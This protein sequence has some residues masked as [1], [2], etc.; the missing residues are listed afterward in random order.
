MAGSSNRRTLRTGVQIQEGWAVGNLGGTATNENLNAIHCTSSSNCWGVAD[1]G[2]VVYWNGSTWTQDAFVAAEN[3]N[4]ISCADAANC[5]I[6]GDAG[7]ASQRPYTIERVGG[8]AWNAQDNSALNINQPLNGVFCFAGGT[9]WAVGDPD[10]A[11]NERPLILYWNGANWTRNNSNLNIN[12]A[13][14]GVTCTATN[15]CWAVG[16]AGV[17]AT[18]RPLI[19]YWD[20]LTATWQRRNSGLNVNQ[21]LNAVHCFDDSSCMAVGNNGV[22]Y[23]WNGANWTARNTGTGENLNGVWCTAANSCFAVGDNG[24][25][26]QWSGGANWAAVTSGTTENLNA[27][28]CPNA[29]DC[30]AVGDNGTV[31]RWNGTSWSST[32][33]PAL[34]RWNG[35]TWS[36][37]TSLLASGINRDLR[38][39]TA[40]SYTDGWVVGETG[41]NAVAPCPNNRARIGRWNGSGWTCDASSPSNRNLNSVSAVSYNDAWAVGAGGSIVRWTGAAWSEQNAA[42]AI[43]GRELHA[44]HAL[45][46]TEVWAT[47]RQENQGGRTCSSPPNPSAAIILRWNGAWSCQNTGA[48]TRRYRAMFMFPDGTDAGTQPDDGWIVGDRAG[49]NFSIFRWNNPVANQWNNQSFLDATNRERLNSVTML[50]TDGDGLGDDGWAVGRLRNNNLNLTILR[51]N[52]ACAGGAATGTW[53]VCSFDPGAALRQ[54]LNAVSCVHARECWAVG[55]GGLILYWDG[56]NWTVHPQSGGLPGAIT[57]A[58]LNGVDLIGARGQPSVAWRENFP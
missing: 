31:L 47:G 44:V 27:I 34:L 45:S 55:N 56:A 6:V 43:T 32:V 28:H 54:H 23:F 13:L 1:N 58:N 29:S 37:A 7:A 16:D 38:A 4:G 36:D 39:V 48:A 42:Q 24:T 19:L 40:L 8:G 57:T 5:I 15:N 12:R 17:G 10:N 25:L 21:D 22:S 14:N 46:A 20:N 33:T 41:G 9:C 53:T 50:D 3:L 30:F 35:V 18:E 49:D 51:W 26:L 2:V 52:H 11:V